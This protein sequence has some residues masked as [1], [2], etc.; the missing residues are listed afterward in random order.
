MK[1]NHLIAH[2]HLLTN[3]QN[4][5]ILNA[6]QTGSGVRIQPTKAQ[7]GN[8][9]GTILETIGIPLAGEVIKK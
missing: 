3:N 7:L 5:N 4:R 6:L 9:L 2:K 1:I 8:D